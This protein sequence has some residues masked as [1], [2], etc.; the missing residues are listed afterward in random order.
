[1]AFLEYQPRTPLFHYCG[2]GAFDGITRNGSIWLSDLRFANDPKELQLADVIEMLT[3]NL[4]EDPATS[5]NLRSACETLVPRIQRLRDRWGLN[6][7]SLSLNADQLPMWQEY[8]ERGRGFCIGFRATA[9]NQMPLRIQKVQYV[10]DGYFSGVRERVEALLNPLIGCE[11]DEIEQILA[12]SRIMSLA[13]SVKDHSWQHEEE[14]RLVFSSTTR[15]TDF[16][17]GHIFPIGELPNGAAVYAQEPLYRDRDGSKV[18]YHVKPFG[19]L[20]AGRWDAS[21]AIKTV[22]LGPNNTRSTGEV[23][24]D[25]FGYGYRDFEVIRSRCAFR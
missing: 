23:T 3:R 6:S 18:P 2:S 13:T 22:I 19:H 25:L 24:D 15:P 17:P 11:Y 9:F 16:E 14:I 5:A 12:A 10:S 8:T 20:R 7:F 21:G 4:I 1:M